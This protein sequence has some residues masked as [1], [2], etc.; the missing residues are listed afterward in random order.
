MKKI[1][2]SGI[3]GI[4]KFMLVDDEDFERMKEYKWYLSSHGYAVRIVHVSGSHTKKNIVQRGIMAHREIMNLKAGDGIIVDHKNRDRLDN[5]KLNLRLT[6]LYGN[7]W[8][9]SRENIGRI[10]VYQ[11]SKNCFRSF[12]GNKC[13]GY[14]KTEKDAALAYDK[15]VREIRGEFAVLNYPDITDYSNLAHCGKHNTN[16]RSSTV[17]HISYSH[18]RK[19]NLKWRVV[20]KRKHLGWFPTEIAA[21]EFLKNWKEN[22]IKKQEN[23]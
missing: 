13:L 11:D 15:Y 19:S 9:T 7:A 6:N 17:K 23:N 12:A 2:L 14:Y 1:E 10:G 5:Q 4:G 20:V 21:I 16:P 3:T 8:N 18:T 22:E